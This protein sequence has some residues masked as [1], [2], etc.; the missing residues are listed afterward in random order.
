MLG[1]LS[2]PVKDKE[3]AINLLLRLIKEEYDLIIGNERLNL[4]LSKFPSPKEMEKEAS[5]QK[6]ALIAILKNANS[7][8]KL[9]RNL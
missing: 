4:D 7:L 3:K 8:V 2:V 9:M 5:K 6:D 1:K